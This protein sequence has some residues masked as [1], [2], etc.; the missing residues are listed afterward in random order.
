M[1]P[2][3]HQ[4]LCDGVL[5]SQR[6]SQ[7]MSGTWS[8]FLEQNFG[9]LLM[10]GGQTT[11]TQMKWTHHG[12]CQVI[13]NKDQHFAEPGQCYEGPWRRGLEY[14]PKNMTSAKSEVLTFA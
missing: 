13:T 3:I 6:D 2:N 4:I 1:A 10:T 9:E 12:S 8:Y 11:L 5:S 7:E 14:N